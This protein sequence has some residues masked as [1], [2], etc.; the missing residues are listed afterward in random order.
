MLPYVNIFVSKT[1]NIVQM[2]DKIIAALK[3]TYANLGLSDKAFDGVAS[4]AVAFFQVYLSS[5]MV[6][7]G[8]SR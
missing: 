1:K 4:E 2:K 8:S 7:S 3:T 6:S 5:K